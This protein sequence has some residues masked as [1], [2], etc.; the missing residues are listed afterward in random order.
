MD[1]GAVEANNPSPFVTGVSAPNVTVGGGTTYQ[2]AITFADNNAI[3]VSTLSTA[4]A[5]TVTGPG[6]FSQNALFKSVDINTNGTPRTATFEITAPGGTFDLAD[7]GKY[8]ITVNGGKIFDTDV[9]TPLSVPTQ[10][11]GEFIV[12]LPQTFVVDATNDEVTDT[13]GKTSLRERCNWPTRRSAP[14]AWCS[15]KRSSAGRRRSR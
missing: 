4:G 11:A 1:I 6:G 8:T 14:T 9:P 12:G 2:F 5:V 7:N 15:T 3:N 10:K 13:D